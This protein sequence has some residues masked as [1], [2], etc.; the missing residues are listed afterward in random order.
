[1]D[2]Q[3]GSMNSKKD[4]RF[5]NS[6]FSRNRE[7]YKSDLLTCS[8][9]THISTA[10]EGFDNLRGPPGI[11][12]VKVL[13][14]SNQPPPLFPKLIPLPEGPGLRT[15]AS[16]QPSVTFGRM[17]TIP[18]APEGVGLRVC[19]PGRPFVTFGLQ[20]VMSFVP[21]VEVFEFVLLSVHPIPSGMFGSISSRPC[22]HVRGHFRG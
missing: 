3:T 2:V 7:V 12:A 18:F 10:D 20:K 15:C 1:M 17:K 22:K 5:T 11:G 8:H 13:S 6:T 4:E 14:T 21:K 19:A 9:F 16:E